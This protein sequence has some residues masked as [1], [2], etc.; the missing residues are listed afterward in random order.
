MAKNGTFRANM[1]LHRHKFTPVKAA[2]N[3]NQ[4]ARSQYSNAEKRGNAQLIPRSSAPICVWQP[5]LR[6]LAD[7]FDI[8]DAANRFQSLNDLLKVFYVG[9]VYRDLHRAFSGLQ[10][11]E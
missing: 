5:A 7:P 3:I 10:I 4:R 8:L 9:Y 2:N 1:A 11:S 6:Y